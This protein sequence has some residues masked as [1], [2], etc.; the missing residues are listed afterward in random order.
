MT[1][2][3]IR[4]S[5][6]IVRYLREKIT[7]PGKERTPP[8]QS[9]LTPYRNEILK[10]W[11]RRQTLREIQAMLQKYG[12][13]ISLPRI[14]LFIKRHKN[15]YDPKAEP[16]KKRTQSAKAS[17]LSEKLNARLQ[18]LEKV[19]VRDSS[20]VAREYDQKHS[21]LKKKTNRI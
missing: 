9:K 13:T 4:K 15:K 8:F 14:S 16:Q 2:L 7:M 20:E 6:C 19:R 3:E 18:A 11:F 21:Q 17:R 5:A 10:A 12:I 1:A